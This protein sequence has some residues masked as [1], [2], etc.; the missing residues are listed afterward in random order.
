MA[1]RKYIASARLVGIV[2]RDAPTAVIF[3]RGPSK[4]VR[5][6]TWNLETD[7]I[8]PGQW[9]LGKVYHERSDLSPNGRLLI[10]FAGKFKRSS[11]TFTAISR[12]PH[13]TALAFWPDTSTWGGGGFFETDRKIILNYGYL[14]PELNN[15]QTIPYHLELESITDFKRNRSREATPYPRHGWLVISEGSNMERKEN[16]SMTHIYKEPWI[17]QKYN[18]SFPGLYLERL[19]VGRSQ[20]NGPSVVYHYR[21]M[22][23]ASKKNQDKSI[24]EEL[25]QM[26]WADWDHKGNFIFSKDGCLFRRNIDFSYIKVLGTEKLVSDL[27]D[28]G[29]K[30]VLPSKEAKL[31]PEE[32]CM[33]F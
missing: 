16:C 22:N 29:W 17:Y 19:L 13:F 4:Q 23:Y 12:P 1:K 31:W 3:R 7:L 24:V 11:R 33:S 25:G 9:L 32:Y 18:P 30:T 21:L 20:T 28:Q 27:R 26:D 15:Y 2:A 6:L 10:Y 14:V 5:M 8:T